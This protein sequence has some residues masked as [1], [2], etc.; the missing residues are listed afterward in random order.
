M[1]IGGLPEARI[2]DQLIISRALFSI[3][4][5]PKAVVLTFSPKD[6]IDNAH[7]P[8]TSTEPF[9]FF[10]KYADLG[11]D[12][13]LFYP[14]SKSRLQQRLGHSLSLRDQVLKDIPDD[15]PHPD[16]VDRVQSLSPLCFARPFERF[17]PGEFVIGS[18]DGYLFIDNTEEYRR[19]YKD[20]VT[21]QLSKQLGCLDALL[22][23][24]AKQHITVFA[25]DMPLTSTN[26]QLL[27]NSFWSLYHTRLYELC[28][29][30]GA[31]CI[32]LCTAPLDSK[33]DFCDTAHL[34]LHGGT[35]IAMYLARRIAEKLTTHQSIPKH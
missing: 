9:T 1:L 18:G 34:N 28:Q 29:K 30:H 35:S 23:Y 5:S 24:L 15:I 32:D 20:P 31:T 8:D 11:S 12:L 13:D 27:P 4:S 14:E 3:K 19:K 7:S 26:R 17:C 16:H 22:S 25:V 2:S 10:S 33:I 6:F 21:G